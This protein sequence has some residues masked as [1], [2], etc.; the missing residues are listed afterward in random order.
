MV[1]SSCDLYITV[2]SEELSNII[3]KYAIHEKG[4]GRLEFFHD[5]G[6]C[7]FYAIYI[8]RN[9]LYNAVPTSEWVLSA[10]IVKWINE[11]IADIPAE[12]KNVFSDWSYDI[13]FNIILCKLKKSTIN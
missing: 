13:F 11:I 12:A 5:F 9:D 3:E 2:Q 6:A 1:E 7:R 4:D 8:D 10:S